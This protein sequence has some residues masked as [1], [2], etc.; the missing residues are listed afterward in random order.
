MALPMMMTKEVRVLSVHTFGLPANHITVARAFNGN[1]G[2][3]TE[4]QQG[5]C[6]STA[7]P[8]FKWDTRL[9]KFPTER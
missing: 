2:N 3:W 4:E 9:A 7:G 5:S 6:E 1:L 8:P